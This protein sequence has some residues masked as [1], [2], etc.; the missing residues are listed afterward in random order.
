MKMKKKIKIVKTAAMVL[1]VFIAINAKADNIDTLVIESDA[2]TDCVFMPPSQTVKARR[3]SN[4]RYGKIT[5]DFQWPTNYDESWQNMILS[6]FYV[7]AE[8]WESYLKNDSISLKIIFS[9]NNDDCDIRT[10]V[11][12]FDA[13]SLAYPMC[14]YRKKTGESYSSFDAEISINSAINWGTGIGTEDTT[15]KNLTLSLMQS[16]AHSMG[17]GASTSI[18][19]RGNNRIITR[20]SNSFSPFETLIFNAS[21]QKLS[22]IHSSRNRMSVEL[23]DFV[24]GLGGSVYAYQQEPAYQLYAPSNF[25]KDKSLKYLSNGNAL[26]S[27]TPSEDLDLEVDDITLKLLGLSGWEIPI[28]QSIEIVG[29]GIDSTGIA[30]AYQS[31]RFF[32]QGDNTVSNPQWSLTLQTVNGND[33]IVYSSSSQDFVI[34]S[35]GPENLFRHSQEGEIKGKVHFSGMIDNHSVTAD[36]YVTFELKPHITY[37]SDIVFSPGLNSEYYDYYNVDFDVRY[38]GSHYLYTTVEEEYSMFMESVYSNKPYY[39]HV[40]LENVD[41][42]GLVWVTIEASNSYGSDSRILEL[43]MNGLSRNANHNQMT[44]CTSEGTSYV[45]YDI[46]GN[47]VMT[48]DTMAKVF[49][50]TEHGNLYI[51]KEMTNGIVHKTIKFYR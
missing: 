43:E 22:D 21:G 18:Y 9:N 39:T 14:L 26:M 24:Q 23:N 4:K 19:T 33:T 20:S 11:Y 1:S 44:N 50:K 31:H 35:I 16:I 6:S 13:D 29:E 7:A 27:L 42:Y 28:T 45:I 47:Q 32:I 48:E 38:E 10:K 15:S 51:V 34:P 8:T 37:V 40:H 5:A 17:F 12:Y 30:S 46:T 2:V 3:T 49:S 36:Y 41:F 25:N